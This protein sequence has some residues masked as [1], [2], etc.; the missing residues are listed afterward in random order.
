MPLVGTDSGDYADEQPQQ[1]QQQLEHGHEPVIMVFSSSSDE[2]STAGDEPQ[3]QQQAF[4]PTVVSTLRQPKQEEG[5]RNDK[6]T[7]NDID[8]ESFDSDGSTG[9]GSSADYDGN[10]PPTWKISQ[11][12]ILGARVFAEFT[13]GQAYWG[14]IV[15]IQGTSRGKNLRYKVLYE[16]GDVLDNLSEEHV[17]TEKTYIDRYPEYPPYPNP[18]KRTLRKML[19]DARDRKKKSTPVNSTVVSD[20]AVKKQRVVDLDASDQ[21]VATAAPT[22]AWPSHRYGKAQAA[23]INLMGSLHPLPPTVQEKYADWYTSGD[24]LVD[25]WSPSKL[26]QK[27]CK[28]CL[29]CTKKDCGLCTSCLRNHHR[30]GESKEICFHRM[31]SKIAPKNK[32]QRALGFPPGYL[33][34]FEEHLEHS[35]SQSTQTVQ[36]NSA[37]TVSGLHILAPDGRIFSKPYS[38]ARLLGDRQDTAVQQ[39][40]AHVGLASY[41]VNPHHFLVGRGYCCEWTDVKGHNRLIFGKISKCFKTRG[42]PKFLVEYSDKSRSLLN[43]MSNSAY[44]RPIPVTEEIDCDNAWGGCVNFERNMKLNRGPGSVIKSLDR[45]MACRTVIVPDVRAERIVDYNGDK[46]PELTLLVRGYKLVFS[47]KTSTIPK[48]G[49]GVFVTCTSLLPTIAGGRQGGTCSDVFRLMAGELLDLG[50][51]APFKK[52]DTKHA[53]VFNCKTYCFSMKT[54]NYSFNC[55]DVDYTYDISDDKTGEPHDVARQ[56]IPMYFNETTTDAETVHAEHDPEG[57]VVC[58]LVLSRTESISCFRSVLSLSLLFAFCCL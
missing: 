39:F 22:V 3:P 40:N 9:T 4:Q 17:I 1:F 24:Q 13:N 27:R 7:G 51:Y 33:F 2:E 18:K 35:F 6:N 37:S 44:G 30:K 16:D 45:T 53:C 34:Y 8:G 48:A 58:R 31:C 55:P 46:V 10:G 32:A 15:G 14:N 56:H 11:K 23:A 25:S 12:K 41:D 49:Y 28:T 52:S 47:V 43:S 21:A 36:S 5:G 29:L 19:K 20:P 54:E 50:I 57:S 42:L 26:F 38:A